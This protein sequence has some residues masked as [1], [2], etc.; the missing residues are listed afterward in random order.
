MNFQEDFIYIEKHFQA[1]FEYAYNVTII[2]L[3]SITTER[4]L[5]NNYNSRCL[6]NT[7]QS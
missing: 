1:L 3:C 5:S 6:K 4:L 2:L 7:T